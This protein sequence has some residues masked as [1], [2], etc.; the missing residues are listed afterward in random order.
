M[1]HPSLGTRSTRSLGHAC[2]R[3]LRFQY[4]YRQRGM[5]PLLIGE[6]GWYARS[7]IRAT[8]FQ[9]GATVVVTQLAPKRL[10]LSRGL[11]N[12]FFMRGKLSLNERVFRAGFRG[13]REASA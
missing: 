5:P 2:R 1:L 9:F 8:F 10:G 13:L 7:S 6:I 4:S 11:H 12:G 3:T